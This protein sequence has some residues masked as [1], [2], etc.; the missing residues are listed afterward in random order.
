[1]SHIIIFLFTDHTVDEYKIAK[2]VQ[3]KEKKEK[4]HTQQSSSAYLLHQCC[5]NYYA[6]KYIFI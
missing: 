1:M 6:E 3:K 5:N 4:K 2:N